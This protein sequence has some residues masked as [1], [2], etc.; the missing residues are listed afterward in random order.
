MLAPGAWEGDFGSVSTRRVS[1][2]EESVMRQALVDTEQAG[3]RHERQQEQT[4]FATMERRFAAQRELIVTTEHRLATAATRA[5]ALSAGVSPS[6]SSLASGG[7]AG[8]TSPA[9][10]SVFLDAAALALKPWLLPASRLRPILKPWSRVEVA[11]PVNTRRAIAMA[12]QNHHA[13]ASSSGQPSPG[14]AEQLLSAS[15]MSNSGRGWDALRKNLQPHT[16]GG[17]GRV[18]GKLRALRLVDDSARSSP[19]AAGGLAGTGRSGVRG[20]AGGLSVRFAR[21]VVIVPIPPRDLGSL[22]D[23]LV[24][25]PAT[26]K[27][28]GGSMSPAAKGI[29][30]PGVVLT[31]NSI[32]GEEYDGLP[33]LDDAPYEPYEGELLISSS[34]DDSDGEE[35]PPM[36]PTT[37]S[38]G[39]ERRPSG[40]RK[41]QKTS[42]AG[43]SRQASRDSAKRRTRKLAKDAPLA[44][45][46][47]VGPEHEKMLLHSALSLKLG[48]GTGAAKG[49]GS[50]KPNT[51]S[52]GGRSNNSALHDIFAQ[53]LAE[54]EGVTADNGEDDAAAS[55]NVPHPRLVVER[56]DDADDDRRLS[57]GKAINTS[58]SGALAASATPPTPR[59]DETSRSGTPQPG[60]PHSTTFLGPTCFGRGKSAVVNVVGKMSAEEEEVRQRMEAAEQLALAPRFKIAGL[61]FKQDT[62]NYDTSVA[63]MQ[64]VKAKR[65]VRPPAPVRSIA[66]KP[67]PPRPQE[68]PRNTVTNTRTPRS[69]STSKRTQSPSSPHSDVDMV[70]T[71]PSW[72]GDAQALTSRPFDKTTSWQTTVDALLPQPPTASS[73]SLPPRL[74]RSQVNPTGLDAKRIA[75]GEPAVGNDPATIAEWMRRGEE[76]VSTQHA[77]I[78]T[79]GGGGDGRQRDPSLDIAYVAKA[80][81]YEL[82]PAVSCTAAGAGADAASASHG[83]RGLTLPRLPS[84]CVHRH[85]EAKRTKED[86]ARRRNGQARHQQGVVDD[87]DDEAPQDRTN[88]AVERLLGVASNDDVASFLDS[89]T[90]PMRK[91]GAAPGVSTDIPALASERHAA[92]DRHRRGTMRSK[93]VAPAELPQDAR[94]LIR[95]LEALLARAE[96]AASMSRPPS[97][98]RSATS[99]SEGTARES[100]L[101]A[102]RSTVPQHHG[103]SR[104]IR[105]NTTS[106]GARDGPSS[107]AGAITPRAAAT[108]SRAAAAAI[109]LQRTVV[110]TRACCADVVTR[111]NT[112]RGADVHVP[113][114]TSNRSVTARDALTAKRGD[115]VKTHTLSLRDVETDACLRRGLLHVFAV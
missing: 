58:T 96:K 11:G 90:I 37:T 40:R 17:G 74:W 62:G 48:G 4:A 47:G 38:A 99:L 104:A 33:E 107:T 39:A 108:T 83:V 113:S 51:D 79:S 41:A 28:R 36:S 24:G 64:A 77:R 3:R 97:V 42:P 26:G 75:R 15:T 35:P 27:K 14:D 73:T 31:T 82:D 23:D 46:A 53:F 5:A 50:G 9:G 19:P 45:N 94:S 98:T 20:D 101:A 55:T 63:W 52:N 2:S 115:R 59:L 106:G 7:G 80:T 81:M 21:A 78:V 111:G 92:S 89:A 43:S 112:A 6:G 67:P 34:D 71:G 44:A 88:R 10:V 32:S 86:R 114:P 109:S 60:S 91:D 49:D 8:D 61:T 57:A 85:A 102:S 30:P 110:L 29:S 84:A 66:A 76:H 100:Q 93:P 13:A 69:V 70:D 18:R 16:T 65:G 54:A 105:Q 87:A 56:A 12:H 68:G 95:S 72:R 22:D 25:F 1:V 103:A